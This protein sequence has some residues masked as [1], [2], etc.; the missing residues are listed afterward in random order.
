[1]KVAYK[2]NNR[3]TLI[4]EFKKGTYNEILTHWLNGDEV[5]FY[6]D[7]GRGVVTGI[8]VLEEDDEE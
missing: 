1:M 2:L 3:Q 5:V 7:R 4:C 6:T 8:E